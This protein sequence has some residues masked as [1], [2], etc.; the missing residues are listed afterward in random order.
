MLSAPGV[1]HVRVSGR[2]MACAVRPCVPDTRGS[3][4][5]GRKSSA[6]VEAPSAGDLLAVTPM[7]ATSSH[8]V[9]TERTL[10]P[11]GGQGRYASGASPACSWTERQD[12]LAYI[13]ATSMARV[14]CGRRCSV[15]V[16][17]S[18]PPCARLSDSAWVSRAGRA[19]SEQA[20][21]HV[22]R[23]RRDEAGSCHSLISVGDGSPPPCTQQHLWARTRP[24]MT[25]PDPG[26]RSAAGLRPPPCPRTRP[27]GTAPS[28]HSS[29]PSEIVDSETSAG[30]HDRDPA[31]A[32]DLG[33]G[34]RSRCRSSRCGG[35]IANFASRMLKASSAT[36][37]PSHLPCRTTKLCRN[38][39]SFTDG[40]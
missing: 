40:F 20:G 10:V 35:R 14:E 36:A 32:Q 21:P 1:R 2:G 12:L 37:M 19:G 24:R 25:G 29:C 7:S 9:N 30:R 23:T 27:S 17:D 26:L 11:A 15:P 34:Y 13:P 33:L 28:A 4:G 8:C 38:R 39:Q 22:R 5:R 16:D 6:A 3:G 31:V 18:P